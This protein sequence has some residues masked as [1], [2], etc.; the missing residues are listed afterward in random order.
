M[1]IKSACIILMTTLCMLGN[2]GCSQTRG[3][4]QTTGAILGGVTGALAANSIGKG[5]GR[6]AATMLGAFVGTVVGSELGA[7]LDEIDQ[8]KADEAFVAATR[9]PVGRTIRWNNPNSGHH[10]TVTTIR[11]GMASNGEYCR[12]FQSKIMVGGKEQ[13]AYGTA[14]RR[15]DG[16][17]EIIG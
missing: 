12:E 1:K 15:P 11:D 2:S 8:Q 17:W 7:Y 13:D 14:C 5:S 16:S 3:N 9:A 4:N 6:V 10:G